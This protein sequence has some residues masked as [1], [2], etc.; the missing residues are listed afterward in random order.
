[1]TKVKAPVYIKGS[2]GTKPTPL[3]IP[4]KPVNFEITQSTG[5]FPP[6]DKS[7]KNG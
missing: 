6:P 1:M 3:Q 5:L 2:K 7:G 4:S